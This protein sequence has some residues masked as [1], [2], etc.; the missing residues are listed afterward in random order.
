MHYLQ[1]FL[2]TSVEGAIFIPVSQMNKM[3]VEKLSN[4]PKADLEADGFIIWMQVL[5]NNRVE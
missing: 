4:I 2:G 5:Y 3:G 1:I